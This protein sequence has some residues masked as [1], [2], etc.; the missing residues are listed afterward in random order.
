MLFWPQAV[1][2]QGYG[3]W[4]AWGG[5][6]GRTSGARLGAPR[7]AAPARGARGAARA[8]PRAPRTCP[9][10]N[11]NQGGKFLEIFGSRGPSAG[12][13]SVKKRLRMKNRSRGKGRDLQGPRVE[14]IKTS[15]VWGGRHVRRLSVL[16]LRRG[17]GTQP[18]RSNCRGPHR[19]RIGHGK[20]ESGEGRGD[21]TARR[22]GCPRLSVRSKSEIRAR[23]K[24]ARPLDAGAGASWAVGDQNPEGLASE[25]C[26]GRAAGARTQRVP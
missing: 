23:G 18:F 25:N 21:E 12:P 1:P 4:R 11:K 5:A 16:D 17:A 26:E 6:F 14:K 8:P 19:E 9:R 22:A 3:C 20:G 2:T 7:E 15:D 10:R 24:D 13:G